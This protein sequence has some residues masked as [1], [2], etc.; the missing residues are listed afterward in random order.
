MKKTWA[1]AAALTLALAIGAV[2]STW[3]YLTSTK[4]VT[5][6]FTV[7]KVAITLDETKTD[8]YG[9][10][11][12]TATERVTA[13]QYKLIP[14]HRYVKDPIVHINP[15]SEDCYVFV[16][17]VNGLSGYEDASGS[18][19][20]Q[21]AANGWTALEGVQNV[22]VYSYTGDDGQTKNIVPSSTSTKDLEVFQALALADNADFSSIKE[23]DLGNLNI[24]V[25]AYAIQAD[26]FASAQ[27][28]WKALTA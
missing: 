8:E 21:L 13:N 22:Y 14:G 12:Q 9:T 11:D 3:A 25:T 19:S 4:T 27:A 2:G 15:D 5:N 10:P 16:K 17:V 7:G 6:T 20:N 26:G 1:A 24:V 18:I 23:A 28:A